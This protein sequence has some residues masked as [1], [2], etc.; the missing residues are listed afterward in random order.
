MSEPIVLVD[1]SEIREGKLEELK[2]T[3]HEL[4]EFVDANEARPIA[5]NVYLKED[6][7]Q[8]T[9]VQVHP[10]SASV[11]F[12]MK[13]AGP[14]F[15]KFVELLKLSTMDIYG[16]PSA[17]LLEQMRQKAQMLGN[18]PVHVHELHSGFARFG[19]P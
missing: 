2:T 6:G 14:A 9:V 15:P 19:L 10:D 7:T 5:Y 4:V 16:K 3:I 12:H 13:L 18:A 17:E 1:S 8:M 11:E